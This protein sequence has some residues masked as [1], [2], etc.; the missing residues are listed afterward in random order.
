MTEKPNLFNEAILEILR[1]EI[2]PNLVETLR[3]TLESKIKD[4][5][6]KHLP[7]L[8]SGIQRLY[9]DMQNGVVLRPYLGSNRKKQDSAPYPTEVFSVKYNGP[10]SSFGE[11]LVDFR[12]QAGITTTELS[13]VSGASSN[14]MRRYEENIFP[15]RVSG[16]P[17]SAEVT[18][19]EKRV[20]T[21][22]LATFD[23]HPPEKKAELENLP[24]YRLEE[25]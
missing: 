2:M 20:M 19:H 16:K 24:T 13:R 17:K 5:E 4:C 15:K 22:I 3:D 9:E 7:R 14:T 18:W 6:D 21:K 12:K 25:R 1:K 23:I 11:A 8:I 10:Y